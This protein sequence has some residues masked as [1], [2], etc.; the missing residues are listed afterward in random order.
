MLIQQIQPA[1]CYITF[2]GHLPCRA[3]DF[4]KRENLLARKKISF[5]RKRYYG[6]EYIPALKIIFF[7]RGLFF[8]IPNKK[9]A[10]VSFLTGA[11]FV[12]TGGYFIH[13]YFFSLM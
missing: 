13:V 5:A 12:M 10:P 6:L 7:S 4:S 8:Q 11:I 3:S 2:L 9:R 1:G